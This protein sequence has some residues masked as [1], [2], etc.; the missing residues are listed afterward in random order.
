MGN[1]VIV[2]MNYSGN[3][4]DDQRSGCITVDCCYSGFTYTNILV[5][6]VLLTACNALIEHLKPTICGAFKGILVNHC[7]YNNG[8]KTY[9]TWTIVCFNEGRKC[10]I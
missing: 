7:R 2:E 9:I 1:L 8:T 3:A 4:N 5:C 10:S 6:L